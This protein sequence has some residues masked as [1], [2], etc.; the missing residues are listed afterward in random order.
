MQLLQRNITACLVCLLSVKRTRGPE[1]WL[2]TWRWRTG[3][4]STAEARRT[5]AQVLQSWKS[6]LWSGGCIRFTLRH[7]CLSALHWLWHRLWPS[8]PAGRSIICA[9]AYTEVDLHIRK[10]RDILIDYDL[11][12]LTLYKS[13]RCLIRLGACSRQLHH[14]CK[15]QKTITL[16]FNPMCS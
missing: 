9:A 5:E 12:F 1:I 14:V 6:F 13:Q 3:L 11:T 7:P 15:L 8:P 2:I 16:L 10:T 4:S